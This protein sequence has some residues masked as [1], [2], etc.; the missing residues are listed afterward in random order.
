[1]VFGGVGAGLMFGR[2]GITIDRTKMTVTRWWGLMVPMKVTIFNLNRFDRITVEKEVR[3]DSNSSKT[4][5]PVKLVGGGGVEDLEYDA[6]GDYPAARRLSEELA[7][8]VRLDI[9]DSMSGRTVHRRLDELNESVRD[10]MRRTRER[11]PL[12]DAPWE[13]I[14][15]IR[16]E[17]GGTVIDLPPPGLKPA[18][19]A[20][21]VPA[22]FFVV[23]VGLFFLPQ[24]LRAGTQ[25]E[26]QLIFGG[27]L[28]FFF[29]FLPVVTSLGSAFRKARFRVTIT[30]SRELLRVEAGVGRK[31]KVTEIPGREL[32]EFELVGRKDAFDSATR[33]AGEDHVRTGEEQMKVQ[34]MLAPDSLLGKLTRMVTKS[35]IVARSDTATVRFGKSIP[36][37]ELIYLH[38]IILRALT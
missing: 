2:S 3:S 5:F 7:R 28:G 37:K 25:S 19:L 26:T 11:V 29:I 4:V 6:P 12:P 32:E 20:P 22:L 31:R 33:E 21:I 9:E 14:A 8:F 30:A 34:R 1:L 36:D 10:R 24:L 38:A 23:M 16:E 15:E 27:I 17:A 35:E 18:H 13:M